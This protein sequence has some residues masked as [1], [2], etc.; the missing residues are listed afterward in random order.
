[1]D[2]SGVKLSQSN[3]SSYALGC[4]VQHRFPEQA[5]LETEI[6]QAASTLSEFVRTRNG[7]SL[8]ISPPS[9]DNQPVEVLPIACQTLDDWDWSS[10][11][12]ESKDYA[13]PTYEPSRAP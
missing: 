10:E 11:Q 3:H 5:Q 9:R 13:I 12:Q 4:G 2:T 7:S 1:M 6:H 8:S